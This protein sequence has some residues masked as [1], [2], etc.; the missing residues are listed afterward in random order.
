MAGKAV[1]RTRLVHT[2]AFISAVVA[3]VSSQ[4]R[5][6]DG[7]AALARGDYQPATEILRAIAEDW[8]SQDTV[9]Q[10]FLAGLYASGRGV[11]ADPVR[12]CA[13]YARAGSQSARP[14]GGQAMPL[15][16]AFMSRGQE[17]NEECQ[18]WLT[19]A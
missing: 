8:R 16:A 13:L 18:R 11:A 7:V 4:S 12:A 2:A 6:A 5:T 9:A 1:M 17:F 3:G 10:F 14:F 19:L 15:F